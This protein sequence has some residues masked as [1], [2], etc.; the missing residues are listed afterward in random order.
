M[1]PI[2]QLT[3]ILAFAGAAGLCGAAR[4]GTEDEVRTT[5]E[6][7]VQVQNAH[8]AR[9]LEG[10]L[11]DSSHF[12]WITRGMTIW[13]REAAL[14]RFS[15]LYQ[16]T[17]KLNRNGRR[18]ASCR[19]APTPRSCTFRSSSRPEPPASHPRSR[20]V[21]EPD[22]AEDARWLAG[23]GHPADSGAASP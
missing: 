16:G 13:G 12:L 6:R 4:A 9:A 1:N 5:F 23:D 22:L 20:A 2:R 11:L 17:W 14:Q 7:F 18:C 8:D 3:A 15:Q 19:S 10:L 21:P